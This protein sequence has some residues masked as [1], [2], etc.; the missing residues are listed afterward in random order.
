MKEFYES[1]KEASM[2]QENPKWTAAIARLTP[3]A[4]RE[5]DIRSEFDRDYT[6][7]LHSLSYRR[8][9]HKT[10]VFF[11]PEDDH[12]CTRIEHVSLVESVSFTIANFLGLNTELT[13][14]IAIGHDIG[15][16]PF[17]HLGESILSEISQRELDCPFWHEQNGLHF[18]DDVE[19]ITDP[20]NN[21]N[22][23]NLTYAVRDGI[24]SHCGEVDQNGIFPRD[25]AIDLSLYKCPNQYSPFTWEG[26]VVKYS[27]KISYLGRDIED[28]IR[29]N[30]INAGDAKEITEYSNDIFHTDFP[31]INTSSLVHLFIID[32]CKN[33]SP[34]KGLSFSHDVYNVMKKIMK[35]N[36]INIYNS[37]RLN[38]YKNYATLAINEIYNFLCQ[39][40]NGKYTVEK[41]A[42][43]DLNYHNIII[44][45]YKWLSLRWDLTTNKKQS[46]MKVVYRVSEDGNAYKKAVIDYIAGMTDNYAS[47]IYSSICSP[48]SI[49]PFRLS[50]L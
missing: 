15:H 7:L 6:R 16:A 32:L 48:S 11:S 35:F 4:E 43:L 5:F 24:I 46:N 42:K 30:I 26:C 25:E 14:A 34:E 39:A 13:K 49:D 22:N 8:L 27:D 40:Y 3:I 2:T 38:P 36:Y 31:C 18:V 47:R 1:F 10:Q 12:V 17:G 21:R 29:F 41:F 33:S 44:E 37:E 28:A 20:M 45:F 50:L 23:L 9:K 19:S